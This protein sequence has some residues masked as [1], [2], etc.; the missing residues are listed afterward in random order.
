[1]ATLASW[2]EAFSAIFKEGG[3]VFTN[4]VTG[5][6]PGLIVLMTAINALVSIIGIERVEEFGKRAG[7]DSP[8]LWPVRYF[9][10]PFTTGFILTNPL[11]HMMGKFLP[12]R[13][14]AAWVENSFRAMHYGL[15]VFPHINP[16]EIFTWVGIASGVEQLG[17]NTAELG[18]R[19]LLCGAVVMTISGIITEKMYAWLWARGHDGQAPTN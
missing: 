17:F 2:A 4:I 6:L 13:F 14:K 5:I 7:G 9:V 15:G 16:G 1:V 3:N 19:Y 18:V 12:E 11:A 10:Y 8:L